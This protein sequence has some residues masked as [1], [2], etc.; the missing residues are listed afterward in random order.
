MK[1]D[2]TAGGVI[3]LREVFSGVLFETAEG[4][5]LGVC[6]RDG[7]FEISVKDTSTKPAEQGAEYYHVFS[8]LGGAIKELSA[9]C[10]CGKKEDSA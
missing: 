8:A 2:V 1:I 3:R 4:E 5:K 10:C 7:G 6:M 9:G